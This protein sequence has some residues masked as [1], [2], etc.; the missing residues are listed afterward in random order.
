MTGNKV[1]LL[2]VL[3]HIHK[4]S[5]VAKVVELIVTGRTIPVYKRNMHTHNNRS[6][7]VY[8]REIFLNPS[9]HLGTE[10]CIVITVTKQSIHIRV[11]T[12]ISVI[13]EDII[14]Q[15]IVNLT[16]VHR[17]VCRTYHLTE[18]TRSTKIDIITTRGMTIV[19]VVTHCR[20][21]LTRQTTDII[22]RMVVKALSPTHIVSVPVNIV[23]KVTQVEA[24]YILL[25]CILRDKLFY[26][27]L[28]ELCTVV[29]RQ[30]TIG[31]VNI[32]CNKDGVIVVRCLDK[33]E[34][35]LL[36]ITYICRCLRPEL[37]H[38]SLCR[39]IVA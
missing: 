26:K 19:V 4:G 22:R 33:L 10:T 3:E 6:I 39:N 32:G 18:R 25:T 2:K 36:L 14:Q 20:P 17:N 38:C 23:R 1:H 29:R 13:I 28:T 34:V 35:V 30:V 7:L 11:R 16:D 9:E 8:I 27:A 12:C 37:R 24:V 15:H 21:E 5:P 31:K